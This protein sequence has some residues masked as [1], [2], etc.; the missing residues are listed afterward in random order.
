MRWD[1]HHYLQLDIDDWLRGER[2]W[3][4]FFELAHFL[5][6]GSAYKSALLEDRELAEKLLDQLAGKRPKPQPPGFREY[7]TVVERLMN[8]EDLLAAFMAGFSEGKATPVLRPKSAFQELKKERT[9]AGLKSALS[10]LL[11]DQEN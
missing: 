3:V 4:S 9:S 1:F 8:I 10:Q 5:P 7:S 6:Q 2:D 11:P